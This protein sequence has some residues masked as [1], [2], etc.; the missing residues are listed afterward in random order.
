MDAQA[1]VAVLFPLLGPATDP[2]TDMRTLVDAGVYDIRR[3][4]VGPRHSHGPG[5]HDGDACV[6]VLEGAAE[7][8]VDGR[9]HTVAAGNLLWVKAEATRGFVAG[10]DGAVLLA[11]HLPRGH[12]DERHR[13]SD[14]GAE[15]RAVIAKVTAHHAEMSAR[16]ERLS[17][18]VAQPGDG[19]LLTS[20]L[21]ALV[22]YL[23]REVLPHAAA[24]EETIYAD[25]RETAGGAALV[26]ALVLEHQDLR[27]RAQALAE[28]EDPGAVPGDGHPAPASQGDLRTRAATQA[29]TVAALFH[30][31][32]RKE[33]EV[34][35]PA[36]VA[37]GRP[38]RPILARMERAF[39]LARGTTR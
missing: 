38:L 8:T 39:S 19:A 27:S 13:G 29:A 28:L 23:R 20:S 14:V 11:I 4:A 15:D 22:E 26:D 9:P 1:D 25:A 5:R 6:L 10:D 21:S 34:V 36:L 32:A 12:G 3:V 24:E 30:V 17:A 31:H 2:G 37:A 33:N 16:L 35:F 18:A 7:F